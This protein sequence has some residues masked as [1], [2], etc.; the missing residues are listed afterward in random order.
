MKKTICEL[1]AGVGGFR[2]GFEKANVNWETVW[3]S[4]WEPG[5]KG[6]WA[7]KC[8]I[9]HWPNSGNEESNKDIADVD[10]KR[11]PNHTLLVG[12]FP[13]QDYS[14]ARPLSGANGIE[15]K[16]G[17]LWW[18]IYETIAVK[19]PPFILLE[20]VD[21]LLRSPA[22]QRGR[23]FGVMLS[24]LHSL[25]Y[26]AEWRIINAADYGAAQ[27][28]R[29]IF[30]FAWRR[31]TK[32]S[33]SV[34]AEPSTGFPSDGF[35][36]KVFPRNAES[37]TRET[38]VADKNI[39]DVSETFKFEFGNNGYLYNGHIVTASVL[40]KEEGFIPLGDILEKD[41]GNKYFI[42]E[43]IAKWEYLKGAKHEARH[44]KDGHKYNYSEGAIAFPDPLNL[45]G[46]TMLT[47]ESTVNRSS[48]VVK[49]PQTNRLR[50]I[51]PIEA[52]RMQGFDDN[53][54][55]G[56][57]ERSRYF[58]IGNALVVPIVERMAKEIEKIVEKE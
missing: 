49:D 6:Q 21:R 56:M 52:E 18:Q 41:V 22:Y 9:S 28:R 37:N 2:L 39:F 29:R 7:Y 58:C 13:C 23:D 48:H 24:C 31:D 3:F 8:Y 15:G 42:N 27:R 35:F 53:W 43:K 30:I 33:A 11:I 40:A 4:Q 20:N 14:V 50:I 12:G 16:K 54:T 17:I 57:P 38:S 47:S 1:F 26:D 10:K 45:P 5:Q 51:T 55:E 25:G 32:Y 44:H 36:T 46:R 19:Q 34:A